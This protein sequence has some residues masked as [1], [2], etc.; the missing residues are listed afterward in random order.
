MTFRRPHLDG[1]RVRLRP[2]EAADRDALADA[3]A[4][5]LIWAQHPETD[6][7]TEAGFARY[8]DGAIASGGALAILEAGTGR[9]IGSSRYHG[10]DPEAREVE[11]G[12]TF[13]VRDHW[14]G[15]TNAEVKRLMLDHAFA[16]VDRVLF[17][18]GA[19]NLR[20][21]R[22]VEKLGARIVAAAGDRVTYALTADTW[23]GCG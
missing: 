15:P 20:S 4:D 13:L 10:H 1:A 14:G 8:F 2:L 3:A 23:R 19:E 16:H 22:A 21:R 5:P 9:M 18:I 7:W 17:R 11:I 6:R 12:W